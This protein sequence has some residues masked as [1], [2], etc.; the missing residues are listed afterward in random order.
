MKPLC[1]SLFDHSGVWSAPWAATH[2]VVMVDLQ[3]GWNVLHVTPETFG[4]APD[5][6]LAAPPCTVFTKASS[7]HWPLYEASGQ[8]RRSVEMVEH[9]L[10]LIRQWNPRVWALENPVGRIHTLVPEVMVLGRWRFSPNEYAGWCPIGERRMHHGWLDHERARKETF[11]YGRCRRPVERPEPVMDPGSGQTVTSWIGPGKDRANARSQTP[12]GF[13]LAF[14][15]ANKE[16][17]P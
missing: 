7:R 3:R 6:V 17:V 9:T 14:Y 13:A 5:V 8:T 4:R 15:A 1:V 10:W 2:E 11:I 12:R 16:V